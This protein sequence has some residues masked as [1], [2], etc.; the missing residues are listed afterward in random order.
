MYPTFA[1][2]LISCPFPNFVPLYLLGIWHGHV[3]IYTYLKLLEV[4]VDV[5][6]DE[7]A[8]CRESFA[9]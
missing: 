9:N 7:N 1:T 8:L 6:G 3:M 2:S 4:D 5:D